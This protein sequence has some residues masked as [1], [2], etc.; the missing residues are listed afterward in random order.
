MIV[1]WIRKI[2]ILKIS[3]EIGLIKWVSYLAQWLMETIV[4]AGKTVE[5]PRV[6]P[7][8]EFALEELATTRFGCILNYTSILLKQSKIEIQ[9]TLKIFLKLLYPNNIY[10]LG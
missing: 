9:L 5:L 2:L 8:N 10:N 4:T 6:Q 7:I 3:W 1:I